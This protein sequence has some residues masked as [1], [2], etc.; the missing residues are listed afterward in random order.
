VNISVYPEYR[1]LSCCNN[2]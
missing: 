2:H 1:I